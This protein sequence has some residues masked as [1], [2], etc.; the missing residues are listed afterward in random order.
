MILETIHKLYRNNKWFD[1]F[2]RGIRLRIV[3]GCIIYH[4]N[5]EY[6]K[7]NILKQA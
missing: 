6:I 2:H 3:V 1:Y 5:D 4:L 7:I